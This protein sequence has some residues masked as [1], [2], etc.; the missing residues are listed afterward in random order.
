VPTAR[1]NFHERLAA[2]NA[3]IKEPVI[4][5]GAPSEREHN[6]RARLFRNGLAVMGFGIVEDFVRTRCSEILQRI[7]SG[8]TAFIDLPE[9][10][11]IAA[12]AGVT[13][14]IRFK[15]SFLDK[16][17]AEYFPLYQTNSRSI[18]ST[19]EV[20]YEIS[21][22]AFGYD[23]ANIQKEDI[24]R[25]LRAFNID[26]HWSAVSAIAIRSGASVLD[27]KSAFGNAL[28]RRNSAAHQA[29]SDTEVTDLS[30]FS[31]EA[32]AIA[33]GLDVMLSHALRKILDAN[34]DFLRRKRL[35]AASHI[36]LRFIQFDGVF[37]REIENNASRAYRRNKD[38]ATLKAECIIRARNKEQ[39]IVI[40]DI[41]GRITDWLTPVV[42]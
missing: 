31:G 25:L 12:T 23:R 1:Q 6:A 37:W 17:S 13:D 32:A 20:A 21:P 42:D 24:E 16:T 11:R 22:I 35:L 10:L 15:S 33:L 2:Y 30:A 19:A 14:A 9:A 18:A 28:K 27:V 5:S 34:S 29:D 41:A 3:A 7:G 38:L 4:V 40:K 8:T 39:A 26:G 36:G